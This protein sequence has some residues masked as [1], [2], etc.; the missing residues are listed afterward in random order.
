[1]ANFEGQT[2]GDQ[3]GPGGYRVRHGRKGPDGE[4]K[5]SDQ[6]WVIRWTKSAASITA[7]S[8]IPCTRASPEYR[9]FWDKLGRGEFDA[10]QYKR[11]GKGGREVWIQASYNPIFD[12]DGKPFKVV[13]YATDITEQKMAMANF[14]GQ[15]AAIGKAQAVIEFG[16]DG[17][18]LTAND[19]FLTAMGYSLEEIR[20]QHH[21]MF[22]DPAYPAQPGLSPVLGKARPRRIRCG[23]IQAD[24][25]GRPR[26][27]A[28]GQLQS[29]FRPER[30]AVQGGKI[31]HRHHRTEAGDRQ[32]RGPARGHRQGPGGDRVRMDGK[33]LTANENFLNARLHA[34]RDPGPPSQHLRRPGYPERPNTA[35][36][37]K[38]WAAANTTPGNTSG[39]AR[40]A[41]KFGSRP[42][43]IRS[44]I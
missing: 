12:P 24:R 39:S 29:D 43:T 34:A 33:V 9:L 3:Q 37:G 11:I 44:W 8:S 25:Q 35:R 5:F 17:K 32:L 23:S 13:K 42:A 20:G 36:S 18:I 1:M 4:R 15:L 16:L 27:L 14:E 38:S 40:A 31:C 22:V 30:Q 28:A 10:G 19:N 41:A 7:C 2:R 21:S 6:R 26:G